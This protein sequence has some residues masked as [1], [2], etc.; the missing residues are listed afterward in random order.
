MILCVGSYLFGS[1]RIPV[2]MRK[3]LLY[4]VDL[5]LPDPLEVYVDVSKDG[6][7]KDV[8]PA[9][10]FYSLPFESQIL[11]SMLMP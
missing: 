8:V 1:K 2:S 9:S 5:P 6:G 7:A 3:V 10:E 11:G 4:A